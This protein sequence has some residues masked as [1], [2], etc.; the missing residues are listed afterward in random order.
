M[1]NDLMILIADNMA[2]AFHTGKQEK[3]FRNIV[4]LRFEIRSNALIVK[5]VVAEGCDIRFILRYG[6]H[7]QCSMLLHAKF[8]GT[9]NF[10]DS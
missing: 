1:L 9:D 4:H 10:I 2:V 3:F 8:V 7:L 6:D 5:S